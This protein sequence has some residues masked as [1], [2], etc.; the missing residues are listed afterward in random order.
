MV[1]NA[2]SALFK[3]VARRPKVLDSTGAILV[4]FKNHKCGAK[5]PAKMI[6]FSSSQV[7][8]GCD[9]AIYLLQDES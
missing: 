7:H 3:K 6:G 9:S 1:S 2:N 5:R 8:F 4:A